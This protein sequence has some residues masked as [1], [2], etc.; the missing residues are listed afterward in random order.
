MNALAKRIHDLSVLDNAR[1]VFG[2]K[3]HKYSGKKVASDDLEA[4]EDTYRCRLPVD[5]REYLSEI[6]SGVGPY[7]GLLILSKVQ[8]ELRIIAEDYQAANARLASPGDSFQ[9][10]QKV[11]VLRTLGTLDFPNLDCPKTQGG[12]MPICHHG[13]EFMTVLIV[14]GRCA[15]MVMD[16]TNFA[17]TPSHWFLAKCPPGIVE[18][19]RPRDPISKFPNWPTFSE[20]IDGWIRQSVQDLS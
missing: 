12:F 3:T 18:F 19:A 14:S 10:E 7:Y 8:Q 17:T 1:R 16:T 13:C 6:G 20:W 4:L 5:Y 9:L 2:A 11:L 15:G